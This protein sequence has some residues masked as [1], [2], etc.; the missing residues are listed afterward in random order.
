MKI[1]RKNPPSRGLWIALLGPDGVGKSAVIEQLQRQL[2]TGSDDVALFHFRPGFRTH[3]V[4]GPPVT[5]PHA[6]RPRSLVVSF[7]KLIYWLVDCWYGYLIVIRR[8]KQRDG[9][10][11]FDRYYPDILVDPIRYR[12]PAR[13]HTFARWFTRMAPRPDLYLLLDAPAEVVQQRKSE[14]PLPESRRQR[15]AYLKMFESIPS[16]LLVNANSPVDEV[17]RN[18]SVA[19]RSFYPDSLVTTPESSLLAGL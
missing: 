18:I 14:L 13:S 7:A 19:I 3:G 8:C 5:R 11:I 12:L 9:L 16:K 4:D 1:P 2:Q 17:A 6:Q 10:V 15:V